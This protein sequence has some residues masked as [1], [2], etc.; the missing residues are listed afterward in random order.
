MKIL[1]V[2][3]SVDFSIGDVSRGYRS[4]LIRAGHDVAD[5]VMSSRFAYHARALPPEMH[6]NASFVAKQASEN[7][8]IEAMYH[9][10]DLV[11]IISG[12]NV[13][14]IALWLLKQI[15]TPVAVVLT[16]SPYDDDEQNEW[17]TKANCD[18]TVFTNDAFS[19][20][21]RDWHLLEPS[22]DRN[23]HKPST[24]DPDGDCDVLMIGTGWPERQAF[25]EAVDWTGIKLKLY[26]VWPGILENPSSPLCKFFTPF[27]VDNNRAPGLYSAAKI[28]LNFH[29]NS[30]E[31]ETPGPRVFE[32]A[33]CGAFQLSDSRKR[34]KEIFVDS[35]PTFSSPGELESLIRT[36]LKDPE[37]RRQAAL[38]ARD[39]GRDETFDNRVSSLITVMTKKERF[40]GLNSR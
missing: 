32:L 24:P 18:V 8:A 12:L 31:A 11:V 22:F 9:Q 10:A 34:L 28:N 30:K 33:A 35:I 15:N 6:S 25:L 27:I 17:V 39:Y 2:T 13:H 40:H 20:R 36:Y 23:V 7:I 38:A 21:T 16:E 4:A 1:F 19:A 3:A 37:L 26:G 5:Y 29:R 14:P